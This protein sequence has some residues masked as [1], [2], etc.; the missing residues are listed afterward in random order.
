M[1]PERTQECV[2]SEEQVR[3]R[4]IRLFTF[5]KE[6]TELR[7]RTVRSYD[8]Y[9][10]VLWFHEIPRHRG[11]HCIAW[12]AV[13]DDEATD[14]WVEVSQPRFNN[15]PDL[16][17]HRKAWI[18]S[19]QLQNSSLQTPS[20]RDHIVVE[21]QATGSGEE[22]QTSTTEIVDLIRCTNSI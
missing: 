21:K 4:S 8:Q 20:I 10:H 2:A 3:N 19:E 5:L 13:P 1:P 12:Q 9:E 11:C 7:S 6:L 14:A 17:P 22:A 18:D 15:S 16:P